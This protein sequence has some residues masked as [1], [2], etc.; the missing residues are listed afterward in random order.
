MSRLLACGGICGRRSRCVGQERGRRLGSLIVGP[1]AGAKGPDL[2]R[3]SKA[4]RSAE[5]V[6]DSIAST[7]ALQLYAL[8]HRA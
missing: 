1:R 7:N 8:A 4:A 3:L 6:A 2:K 5:L